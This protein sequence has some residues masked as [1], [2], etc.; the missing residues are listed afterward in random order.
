MKSS[1]KTKKTFSSKEELAAWIEKQ[2]GVVVG[3]SDNKALN[4]S[5]SVAYI[6]LDDAVERRRV[7]DLFRTFGVSYE[8]HL[9]G[10][11]FVYLR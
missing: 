11:Y 4:K 9:N 7:L 3:Q 5:K 8:E 2:L 10:G 1:L 6:V